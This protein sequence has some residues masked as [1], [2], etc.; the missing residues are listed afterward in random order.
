MRAVEVVVRLLITSG[1]SREPIDDVRFVGNLSSGRTGALLAAEAVR[2]YHEVVLLMGPDAMQPP[3]WAFETGLLSTKKYVSAAELQKNCVDEL[4]KATFDVVV[5]AAAVADF[6]PSRVD[7]KLSSRDGELMVR[8]VPTP[9]VAAAISPLLG[10]AALVLFKLEALTDEGELLRRA[11][12]TLV[13]HSGSLVVANYA[14][15]MGTA[16]HSAIIVDRDNILA[17]C[18]NRQ[19]LAHQ[20]L[21]IL[22]E[23]CHRPTNEDAY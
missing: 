10:Q 15:G 23:T 4:Q 22:E 7:G 16:E 9:K 14:N 19:D 20:L 12:A 13:S 11:R 8:L 5:H 3:E 1:G 17:R 6:A 2:R 18:K 21:D